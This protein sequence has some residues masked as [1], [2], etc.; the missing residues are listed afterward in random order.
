MGKNLCIG[1]FGTCG[2]STWRDEFVNRY[3]ELG[4]DYYNPNKADW[5][6]EY[7]VEEAEHLANDK[8]ILFPITKETYGTGSL[9][10]VGFSILNAIQLDDRRNFVVMIEQD[11]VPELSDPIAR[12]ESL[13]ARALVTQHLKKLRL[14]NLYVV[15]KLDDMLKVSERLYVS[16]LAKDGLEKYNP[17]REKST[18]LSTKINDSFVNAFV[19]LPGIL[20]NN[21]TDNFGER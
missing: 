13:K 20:T 6:P 5:K 4:L 19:K 17:H 8:I 1:L 10:E 18:T 14:D 15:D 9:A 3:E 7:A 12:K 16:E 21:K 2:T 11:L